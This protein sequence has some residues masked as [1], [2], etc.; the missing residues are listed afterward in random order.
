M[1]MEKA[2]IGN[3]PKE[4]KRKASMGGRRV[5]HFFLPFSPFFFWAASIFYGIL[6]KDSTHGQSIA[7]LTPFLLLLVLLTARGG[8]EHNT[9]FAFLLLPP[10]P[11]STM[12]LSQLWLMASA[13]LVTKGV[14]GGRAPPKA[15]AK[16]PPHPAPETP[17]APVAGEGEMKGR[18]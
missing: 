12:R 17:K 13:A 14:A 5:L 9:F 3:M 1:L 6:L 2:F 7:L 10:P 8:P 15:P 18:G 4:E 11:F 16:A